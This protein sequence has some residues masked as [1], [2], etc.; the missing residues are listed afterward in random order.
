MAIELKGSL[1]NLRAA[2][3]SRPCYLGHSALADWEKQAGGSRRRVTADSCEG[4]ADPEKRF[5]EKWMADRLIEVQAI[6]RDVLDDENLVLTRESSANTV[7]DW[8]S[9]AHVNLVT[10]IQRHYQVK[11][12]LGE[13]QDMKNVGDLLD[14]LA[15]KL[16]RK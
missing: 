16:A 14:L 15:E 9:L 4:K 8:D 6:F 10:A 7:D 11:F 3:R 2:W 1:E 13:L 12:A 5:V